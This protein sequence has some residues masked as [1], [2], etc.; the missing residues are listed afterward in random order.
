MASWT[1]GLNSVIGGIKDVSA[2]ASLVIDS[3]K[4]NNN[5]PSN[6]TSIDNLANSLAQSAKDNKKMILLIGGG[7]LLILG[8]A[9][10]FK[11]R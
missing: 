1:E 3:V 7:V 11:R 6:N 2:S 4:G 8:I 5:T 10:I 9:L